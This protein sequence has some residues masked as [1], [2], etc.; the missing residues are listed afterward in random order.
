MKN[1][2]LITYLTILV[3]LTLTLSYAQN[4]SKTENSSKKLAIVYAE[5]SDILYG[6]TNKTIT[7]LKGNVKINHEDIEIK[8]DYVEYYVEHNNKKY[9]A[10]SPGKI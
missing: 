3:V 6:D 10:N 5:D 4:T 2:S 7:T 1:Q 9:I 8:S